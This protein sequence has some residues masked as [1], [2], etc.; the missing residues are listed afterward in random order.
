MYRYVTAASDIASIAMTIQVTSGVLAKTPGA[1]SR[2][3][4]LAGFFIVPSIA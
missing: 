1:A 3:R 4:L 2:Q